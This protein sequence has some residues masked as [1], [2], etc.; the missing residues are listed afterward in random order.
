M[1]IKEY[2]EMIK[3]LTKPKATKEEAA[4]TWDRL[5][6][7]FNEERK[8]GMK[9]LE[10]VAA[11]PDSRGV[12]K[13]FVKDSEKEDAESKALMQS[14]IRKSPTPVPGYVGGATPGPKEKPYYMNNPVNGKLENVNA[15]G[16]DWDKQKKH[17]E[18]VLDKL[19]DDDRDFKDKRGERFINKTLKPVEQNEDPRGV[20]F[21]P[22]T[23]LFTNKDR[24]VAF[25]T[26]DEADT[27]NKAINIKTKPKPLPTQGTPEQVGA[28]AER[29]ERSRQMTGSDGR[30]DKPII[31]KKKTLAAIQPVKMNISSYNPLPVI[32]RSPQDIAAERNFQKL[33]RESEDKKN[34]LEGL[35]TLLG[36]KA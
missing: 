25:K 30:Y 19:G 29:M 16:F 28:L 31:K 34:R 33:V 1:K 14:V 32:E 23:Q 3:Y 22:T 15:K 35:E 11:Q 6:S 5:E 18:Y 20:A 2:N 26:Y 8:Q 36:R 7:E 12:Y 27:W 4:A 17:T 9:Q 21:N 13:Q 10:K 24:T